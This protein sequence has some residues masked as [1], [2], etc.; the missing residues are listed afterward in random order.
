MS[1]LIGLL[2][3]SGFGS[4]VGWVGGWLNRRVDLE[5]KKA[6]Y[7]YNLDNRDKDLAEL[8]EEVAGR[9]AVAD[10]EVET[11][12][13]NANG[14]IESAAYNA[15]AESYKEQATKLGGKWAW[16]DAYSKLIRPLVTTIFV[17]VSLTISAYI[18]YKALN[19]GVTF[20]VEDWKEW[21]TY[22]VHWVFFQAGVVIGWWFANRPSG[23]GGS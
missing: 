4:L 11:A 3:S 1:I 8:K 5:T 22:V 17:V 2:S 13:V 16:V 6:E 12:R 14:V 19:A 15:M 23:R 18:V 7:A 10:R 21:I 9:V 20:T